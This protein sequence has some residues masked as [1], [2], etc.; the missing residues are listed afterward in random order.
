MITKYWRLYRIFWSNAVSY[1]SQYRAD[2]WL[3]LVT[4]LIWIGVLFSI[5][6]VI[7]NHTNAIVGWS[8]PEVYFLTVIWVLMDEL[9]ITLF[10]ENFYN[11][12]TLTVEG[13]LDFFLIKPASTLFLVTTK[14]I[15]VRAAYRFL[16]QLIILIWLLYHYQIALKIS[17]IPIFILLLILGLIIQYSYS[18]I[19]NTFSFWFLR[20]ENVNEALGT[21]QM[22][23]RY[24][25][26][27]LPK[28]LKILSL[29]VL[30][31]AFTAYL[32]VASILGRAPW[33]LIVYAALF[34][35]VLF[36]ISL[37]FWNFAVRRYSSASS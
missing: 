36:L 5:I 30:P 8:K 7:F 10:R 27:I 28:T 20:I 16:T 13:E 33:Q 4:N 24:P 1:E 31:I 6:E 14:K 12:S 23:G 15:L 26:E 32:P 34:A 35:L 29:T 37:F 9:F 18:L 19:F 25:L 2:T 21:L 22:S 3:K 11:F 17:Y